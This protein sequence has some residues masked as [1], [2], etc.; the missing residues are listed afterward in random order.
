MKTLLFLLLAGVA[1]CSFR[2]DRPVAALTGDCEYN[3]IRLYGKVQFVTSF[4]DLKIQYVNSFP[5][6]KVKFVSA[7]ADDCG[8]WEVVES[9]PDFKVQ[10]VESFPDLKVQVVDHFPGMN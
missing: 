2:S 4:P 6:L 7:F 10:I 8:E 3:G 1:L 5:D 9:F